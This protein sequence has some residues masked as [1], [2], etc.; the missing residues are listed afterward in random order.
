M[1]NLMMKGSEYFYIKPI[2]KKPIRTRFVKLGKP[3][4]GMVFDVQW[5]AS[6]HGETYWLRRSISSGKVASLAHWCSLQQPLPP[7]KQRGEAKGSSG[8][9]NDPAMNVSSCRNR[10]PRTTELSVIK[11][12]K[13]PKSKWPLCPKFLEQSHIIQKRDSFQEAESTTLSISWRRSLS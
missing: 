9:Q 12:T 2:F 3:I 11:C 6:V 4:F 5:S 8:G 1:I 7:H 13:A 10:W